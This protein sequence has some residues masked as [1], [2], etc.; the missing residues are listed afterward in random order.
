MSGKP[1]PLPPG[2]P[3]FSTVRVPSGP[4]WVETS[5]TAH[6]VFVKMDRVL[7][8]PAERPPWAMEGLSFAQGRRDPR[9]NVYMLI[10]I[11]H[12]KFSVLTMP[13]TY[14]ASP[15][16]LN[17]FALLCRFPCQEPCHSQQ[18]P[19]HGFTYAAGAGSTGGDPDQ[20]Q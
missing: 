20:H 11:Y 5:F 19:R 6:H 10:G 13:K 14:S 2:R 4:E 12:Q 1:S 17:L 9:A 8:H 16:S 18:D 3:L 15:N 7:Q